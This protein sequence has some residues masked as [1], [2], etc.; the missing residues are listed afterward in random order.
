MSPP[1]SRPTALVV[2]DAYTSGTG[3]A[4][5]SYACD[6]VTKMGWLCKLAAEPGTG[7]ISDGTAN[8]F[9]IDQGTGKSTSFGE[10][11]PTRGAR[12]VIESRCGTGMKK[13]AS[14]IS[15]TAS[16]LRRADRI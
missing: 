1:P 11:I 16:D 9:P 8:R 14:Q 4:E 10:R 12:T 6:A 15:E 5:T 7:Y 2:S 3:L 13:A